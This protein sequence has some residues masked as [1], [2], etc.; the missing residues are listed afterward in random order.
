MISS[1]I[2]RGGVVAAGALTATV[3]G[4]SAA[5][6]HGGPSGLH[7]GNPGMQRMHELHMQGNPGMQRMHEQHC[8]HSMEMHQ[9]GQ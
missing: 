8:R 5:Q 3:L 1:T 2:A 7:E 6:A 4:V 9:H